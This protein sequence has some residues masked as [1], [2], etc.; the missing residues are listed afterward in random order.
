M[1]LSFSRAEHVVLIIRGLFQ[2]EVIMFVY[3]DRKLHLQ[4][5]MYKQAYSVPRLHKCSY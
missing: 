2:V 3:G 4:V 1:L 5:G